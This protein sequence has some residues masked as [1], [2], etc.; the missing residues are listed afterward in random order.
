M[1]NEGVKWE[2]LKINKCVI[3]LSVCVS[4]NNYSHMMPEEL[5]STQLVLSRRISATP[6]AFVHATYG[7]KSSC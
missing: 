7:C 5:L 3:H 6:F 2:K 4:L 1:R